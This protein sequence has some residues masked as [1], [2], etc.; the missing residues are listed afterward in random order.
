VDSSAL[1]HL[2]H[3]KLA[4]FKSFADA[5][6]IPIPGQRVGIVG[7]NGCGKSNVIDAVR[8]VLGESQARQLRGESLQDV[9]FGGSAQRKPQGRASVELV[10]DNS[11]GRAPGLWSSYAEICVKRVMTRN[12][13]SRYTINETMV[14]RRDV[15]DIFL[16]TGLGPRAYAIIEQG[17]ITRIIEAR[18]EEIRVF[19]EE[20]AG[21]SRY[22][23]RRRETLQHLTET[24]PN[25]ERI[26]D[27]VQELT[28]Q[29]EKVKKQA[30]RAEHWKTLRARHREAEAR[31]YY[32]RWKIA[33]AEQ[34]RGELECARLTEELNQMRLTQEGHESLAEATRLHWRARQEMVRQAQ[35]ALYQ[36]NHALLK[37]ESSVHEQRQERQRM[38]RDSQRLHAQWDIER[39]QW[40]KD[41]RALKCMEE[42]QEALHQTVLMRQEQSRA[43]QAAC[44]QLRQGLTWSRQKLEQA[45][46]TE[47]EIEH[48]WNQQH[49]EQEARYRALKHILAR[50]QQLEEERSGLCLPD[51]KWVSEGEIL[52]RNRAVSSSILEASEVSAR[53]RL[54]WCRAQ[55]EIRREYLAECTARRR[56]VENTLQGLQ[57]QEESERGTFVPEDTGVG[58]FWQHCQVEPRWEKVVEFLL[59]VRLKAL[60]RD[61]LPTWTELVD[62]PRQACAFYHE[63]SST[64]LAERILPGLSP[65]SHQ[66]HSE[67]PTIRGIVNH[68]LQGWYA[69]ADLERMLAWAGEWGPGLCLVTPEGHQR[70]AHSLTLWGM[71]EGHL[72][73][74]ARAREIRRLSA[75]LPVCREAE[76]EAGRCL[77]IQEEGKERVAVLVLDMERRL[78]QLRRQQHQEALA[79][80]QV[81]AEQERIRQ[82]WL[83]LEK[84]A[85]A[86]VRAETLETQV[87]SESVARLGGLDV[88]REN[89]RT[90]TEAARAQCIREEASW[91]QCQKEGQ[92]LEL[93]CQEAR[94]AQR[95][96]A[97][98]LSH[99][100]TTQ[101]ERQQRMAGYRV[102]L[103]C[104]Q[105]ELQALDEE[106][107]VAANLEQALQVQK[108]CAAQLEQQQSE[109]EILEEGLHQHEE[110]LLRSTQ[111]QEPVRQALENLHLKIQEARLRGEQA[112]ASLAEEDPGVLESL[113]R[114]WALTGHNE[115]QDLLMTQLEKAMNA[116]GA[117]NLAALEELDALQQR[118]AW[119]AEQ[120]ADLEGAVQTLERALN[121]I[122]REIRTQL[123]A[124]I[125]QVNAQFARL[126]QEL[127]EGGMASLQWLGED[128]L[129]A[130]VQLM[131]QPPG[132]KNSSLYLLSGGEKALTAMALIF[133]LF[134]LN[135]APFCLLDEVDA[136]LDDTN[137]ERFSRMVQRMSEHTQ[138]L[139]I[140]HNKV[141]MEMAQQLI[142]ITMAESGVSR[143]V[144]VDVEEALRLTEQVIL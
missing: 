93:A 11:A 51:S 128:I 49:A 64:E 23:E 65:L 27:T 56:V 55:V 98:K 48:Q 106:T 124:T 80:T 71:E 136:P 13:V 70:D 21:I 111:V 29:I 17:M 131:A 66:V 120:L 38:E 121:T 57:S 44:E 127:F 105:T 54:S 134:Q 72:G 69:C 129:E 24:R 68:W 45:R 2:K 89:A 86:L 73:T 41:Q 37:A 61:H 25:L 9:I 114:W 32:G 103:E 115:G 118:H 7:P 67:D 130:G 6:H 77:A 132:K 143:M 10:F 139:F 30:E 99:L 140:T 63:V 117:V 123:G 78:Q 84:E 5:V 92:I 43:G 35:G 34:G 16:G 14:R 31:W 94:F 20:V 88:A 113:D 46:Q 108:T 52:A 26:R 107:A 116:L 22:R 112:W 18:P 15:Q 95:S 60:R 91:E 101:N 40:E 122:D 50:R 83:R 28:H 58:R 96:A 119:L 85:E 59:G 138:F 19:L 74:L 104:L 75:E 109:M 39:Q 53:L 142:G 12:G 135:P 4:G 100:S 82:E 76:E 3:I 81:R 97:E 110:L 36:A 47:H 137:T 144:A 90:A 1:V 141:A 125:D 126:F 87:R 102:D 133:A 8:W 62:R 79:L 33:R 42:Q